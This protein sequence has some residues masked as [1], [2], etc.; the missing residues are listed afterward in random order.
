M[1]DKLHKVEWKDSYGSRLK[2]TITPDGITLYIHDPQKPSVNE[3]NLSKEN[4]E[5]LAIALVEYA[6]NYGRI[7]E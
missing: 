7:Y 4:C 2:L 3:I 5:E 6:R 1:P